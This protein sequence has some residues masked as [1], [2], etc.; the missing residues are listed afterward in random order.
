MVDEK[1]KK[2]YY[3]KITKDKTST[4]NECALV[5]KHCT[6]SY[7]MTQNPYRPY[8][9]VSPNKSKQLVSKVTLGKK[10]CTLFSFFFFFMDFTIKFGFRDE[11][12]PLT[13]QVF[14]FLGLILVLACGTYNSVSSSKYTESYPTAIFFLQLSITGFLAFGY[15]I[16]IS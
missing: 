14:F 1:N 10:V 3:T 13:G 4:E 15:H 5:I 8:K 9:E 2:K 7:S 6:A 12:Q 16:Y 11:Q